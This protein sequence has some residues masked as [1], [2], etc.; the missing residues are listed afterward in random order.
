MTAKAG[1]YPN[2]VSG[3][4]VD[5]N[6]MASNIKAGTTIFGIYGGYEGCKIKHFGY[7]NNGSLNY[8]MIMGYSELSSTASLLK[9]ELKNIRFYDSSGNETYWADSDNVLALATCLCCN[10]KIFK[11]N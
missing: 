6:L 2:D 10:G 7:K 1:Y 11:N 5:E 8:N 3:T 9:I 4:C